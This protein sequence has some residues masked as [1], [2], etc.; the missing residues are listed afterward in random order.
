MNVD[1]ERDRSAEDV[2]GAAREL[3]DQVFA[4]A[5]LPRAQWRA[6]SASER[7]AFKNL[8]D[9]Y[10]AND[11]RVALN[12]V[13]SSSQNFIPGVQGPHAKDY[14]KVYVR[15]VRE[16]A[17]YAARVDRERVRLVEGELSN[18]LASLTTEQQEAVRPVYARLLAVMTPGQ[19]LRRLVV[20]SEKF[21]ENGTLSGN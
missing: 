11:D 21:T 7:L 5:S 20:D 16:L 9:S 6:Y 12:L 19:H 1:R 15:G 17:E 3:N 14:V 8:K 4:L 2:L 10:E 13:V 18:F